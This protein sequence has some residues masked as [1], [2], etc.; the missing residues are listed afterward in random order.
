MPQ[1]VLITTVD[2]EEDFDWKQPFSRAATDVTS[3]G[4]QHR[5]HRVFERHG[6]VPVYLADYPVASQDAGR[7][8]LR[9][10]LQ[11]GLCEIGAQ[12]HAWVTPPFAETVSPRNSFPGN[13]PAALEFAKVRALTD[14]LETA[15]GAPPRIFRA[16][17]YGVGPHTGAILAGLGYE[18]DTSVVPWYTFAADGGPDFRSSTAHPYWLDRPGGLLE[19]PVSAALVGRASQLPSRLTRHLFSAGLERVHAPS[20]MARLGLVERIKLTPEGIA[21]AEA[22]LLVRHMVRHGHRVFV[23]TYHSPSLEPGNTPYVRTED[24]VRRLLDW[25]DAFYTFFRA[26]IGGRF[27]RWGEVREALAD[28]DAP[29]VVL[30]SSGRKS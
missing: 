23:L 28:G 24:D 17:R 19:L 3:M 7:G 9:E 15:F 1:P 25:L 5:A 2:A 4:S 30:P 8:P 12:L 27:A 22:Q 18:A 21:L 11:G 20:V 29:A 14:A 16:G 13:L 6:V 26:D 10:L